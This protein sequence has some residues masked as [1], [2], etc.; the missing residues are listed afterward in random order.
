MGQPTRLP[1]V[2][3]SSRARARSPT[4]KSTCSVRNHST[5]RRS[6]RPA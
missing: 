5:T 1:G 6:R 2:R 4:R 3:P